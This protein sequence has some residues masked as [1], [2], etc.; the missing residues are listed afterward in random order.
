MEY[1]VSKTKI[2]LETKILSKLKRKNRG[3]ENEVDMKNT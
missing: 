2:Q 3:D 1:V